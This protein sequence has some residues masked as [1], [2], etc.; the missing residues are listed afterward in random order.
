MFWHPGEQI[1]ANSERRTEQ[2]AIKDKITLLTRS[3]R[4]CTRPAPVPVPVPV[5]KNKCLSLG[6]AT[7]SCLDSANP[8]KGV[9]F[10]RQFFLKRRLSIVPPLCGVG[11]KEITL[12]TFCICTFYNY[13]RTK[14]RWRRHAPFFCTPLDCSDLHISLCAAHKQNGRLLI[15]PIV[16][17]S[18]V[19]LT[20]PL[21]SRSLALCSGACF[22]NCI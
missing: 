18:P 16:Q 1:T 13:F 6:C 9:S 3:L 15:S 10:P 4:T 2:R 22:I 11:Q 17:R 8:H 14:K 19:S 20:H 5:P 12:Q 21:P 7:W